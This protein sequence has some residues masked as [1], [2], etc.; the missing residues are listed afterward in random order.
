VLVSGP[1]H[2]ELELQLSG[3]FAYTPTL[4]YAGS[5]GFTYQ[6]CDDAEPSGCS[7]AVVTITVSTTPV[8]L[9]PL[10]N[11]DAY[12]TLENTP[13]A[14]PAASGVLANDTDPNGDPL[15]ATLDST[16]DHG[17]VILQ[18]DGSF[19]YTPNLDYSGSDG[20]TYQVCDD[21]EPPACDTA[22]VTLIVNSIE[23]IVYLPLV[24]T[25][26]QTIQQAYHTD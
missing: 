2:G 19:V 13:L 7:T 16:V 11:E 5:D 22:A 25:G 17:T 15:T 21:A 4:D 10:A 23:K 24:P 20:F 14:V 12:S 26:T 6:A 9:P 1:L 8:N 3:S 18:P